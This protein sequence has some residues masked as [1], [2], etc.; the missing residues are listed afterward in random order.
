[1]K[2]LNLILALAAPAVLAAGYLPENYNSQI[3][4]EIQ[5][6]KSSVDDDDSFRLAKQPYYKSLFTSKELKKL[7][8]AE[9]Y[10]LKASESLVLAAASQKQADDLRASSPELTDKI[11]KQIA[12]LEAAS[13][14]QELNGLKTFHKASEI[15]R[16][17]YTNVLNNCTFTAT[18]PS[19]KTAQDLKMVAFDYY[20]NADAKL[21]TAD[22]DNTLEV[23]RSIYSY[24]H[25][26]VHYQ[27]I[28]FA[29]LK[30]DAAV[31]Y[32]K[33]QN[34]G[35]SNSGNGDGNIPKD[36]IPRLIA[37]DHY[38]FDKD[39]N[40]YRMRFHQ[41]EERLKVS[42]DD[43][44]I[45]AKVEADEANAATLFGRAETY[46]CTADTFRV[47][48]GEATT[49]A[50]REYYEQK[51]QESELNECSNLLKAVKLEVAAN[52]Q[53]FELYKKYVGSVRN[54][55]DSLGKD[56]EAQAVDLYKLSKTYEDMAAKQYSHV[57]QYTQLMEGN[58][59]KLQALRCMENAIASYLG[60]A[61]GSGTLSMASGA[62]ERHNDVAMDFMM[63]ESDG[64]STTKPVATVNTNYPSTKPAAN[65]V[66][67]AGSNGNK[68]ANTTTGNTTANNTAAN[69]KPAN[70][71]S[72]GSKPAGQQ[73]GASASA[74]APASASASASAAKNPALAASS[75][76]VTSTS[77]YTRNDQ[78]MQPYQYPKGTIFSVEAGIY[79]EMPE[80]VEF[81]AV[82][83][84]LAQN[85]KGVTPLRYYIGEYQTYDAAYATCAAAKENGY[86]NAKV[87]AFVNGKNS[88]V[89][90]AK[91][92]AEKTPGYQNLVQAELKKINAHQRATTPVETPKAQQ[93]NAVAGAAIPLSQL[94]GE[95]YV[96]QISSVPALL[97][98]KAFNVSEL[99]YDRNDGGL[100]RYYTGASNDVN[101]AAANLSTMKQAGYQD[102]YL[103]RVVDGKN[104]GSASS[105]NGGQQNA[106]YPVYRVQVGAYRQINSNAQ[107]QID[108]LRKA[109]YAVHTSKSGEYTVITVGDCGSRQDADK[110]RQELRAKGF[111]EAY[112]VT[113]VNGVKQ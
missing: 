33:Y 82:E 24:E 69:T 91:K 61:V 90:A 67:E 98:A 19:E 1:M 16:V 72:N 21:E 29:L 97:D 112:V 75:A 58:E 73:S 62:S 8:K 34:A 39:I 105:A 111:P 22:S 102:A 35:Q 88:D 9:K 109:G 7:A 57:E 30:A 46:G 14:Q 87:V 104:M 56:M 43:K 23:Y 76:A 93:Q 28:S 26:A 38:D 37:A 70:T 13:A 108:N 51:A 31:D 20:Q 49:L 83:K 100:Y 41:F 6:V 63:D 36:S 17:V 50:E 15:Y 113:F 106:S 110:L 84:F 99:F 59:V 96:V 78:R 10:R 44:K 53:V 81:P 80:P 64:A 107:G 3:I 45:I 65:T 92:A 71:S 103:V 86:R 11:Q 101:I 74:S 48:S 47:Y 60:D 85:L 42:D 2:A 4:N 94:S 89:Q 12:K 68:P 95:Q 18:Q 77:F 52:N 32:T 40:L 25:Q 55:K 79:K 66:V 5:I 54:D 27:E